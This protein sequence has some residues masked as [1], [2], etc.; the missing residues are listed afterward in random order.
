MLTQP[1]EERYHFEM[2]NDAKRGYKM[3]VLNIFC[4][5]KNKIY[6]QGKYLNPKAS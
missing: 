3:N 2:S 4:T 1:K 5:E 6:G